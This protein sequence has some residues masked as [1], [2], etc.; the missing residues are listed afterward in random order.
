MERKLDYS[1]EAKNEHEMEM[2]VKRLRN[3]WGYKGMT[4]DENIDDLLKTFKE[5]REFNKNQKY[6]YPESDLRQQVETFYKM[7][8]HEN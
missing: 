2:L 7:Y 3:N 8:D 1:I 4:P 6:E 5:F